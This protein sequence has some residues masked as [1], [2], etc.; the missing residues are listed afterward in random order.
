MH[1][2]CRFSFPSFF[3]EKIILSIFRTF[4]MEDEEVGKADESSSDRY[5]I[6]GPMFS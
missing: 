3:S 6:I 4:Y 5:E 2:T 1:G